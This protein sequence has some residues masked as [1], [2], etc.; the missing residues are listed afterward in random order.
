MPGVI[1]VS[2]RPPI[3]SDV[4][5]DTGMSIRGYWVYTHSFIAQLTS[6]SLEAF[7]LHGIG[8]GSLCSLKDIVGDLACF[9]IGQNK[10][11]LTYLTWGS[12][13]LEPFEKECASSLAEVLVR[14]F[15][16]G[17]GIIQNVD[18]QIVTDLLTCVAKSV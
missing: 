1:I 8:T 15:R 7:K 10:Q 6:T 14:R 2:G 12:E 11:Q 3:L 13:P 18:L 9:F 5:A 4:F 16:L 17:V